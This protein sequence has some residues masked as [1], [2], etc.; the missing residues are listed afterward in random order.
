MSG[1]MCA[2]LLRL[3]GVQVTVFDK[4]TRAG[5]RAGCSGDMMWQHGAQ[6]M[7]VTDRKLGVIAS[8]RFLAGLLTPFQGS[9]AILGCT[10]RKVLPRETLIATGMFQ[11]RQGKEPTEEERRERLTSKMNFCG[12]LEG[13][14]EGT[15]FSGVGGFCHSLLERSKVELH[16]GSTVQSV[17]FRQRDGKWVVRSDGQEGSFDC[18]VLANNDPSLAA[19]TLAALEQDAP[20]TELS[21]PEVSSVISDFR[22][23]LAAMEKT[24][25]YSLLLSAASPAAQILKVP[26]TSASVHGSDALSFISRSATPDGVEQWVAVSTAQFSAQLDAETSE[27]AAARGS[28]ARAYREEYAA[29]KLRSELEEAL[30]EWYCG[31]VA[32]VA[33]KRW[34]NAF[35]KHPLAVSGPNARHNDAVTFQP[36]HL[37]L[38]GDYLGERQDLQGAALSGVMAADRIL[39]WSME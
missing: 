39:G 19:Q 11:G 22:S 36:W 8:S 12:Y 28:G 21:S 4:G 2:A 34:G 16:T 9:H 15:L 30:G 33:T 10:E 18:L 23:R 13:D 17:A 37:A 32:T 25:R 20:G 27:A 6:F 3:Q 24:S 38:C 5:G 31:N 7:N 14:A 26:F 35:F 1:S 29:E